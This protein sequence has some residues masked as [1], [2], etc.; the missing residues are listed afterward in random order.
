M[1]ASK[2][3]HGS[4]ELWRETTKAQLHDRCPKNRAHFL[5]NGPLGGQLPI[6]SDAT[7]RTLAVRLRSPYPRVR[8]WLT[9]S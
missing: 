9:G 2:T 5:R 7:T 4:V 3:A 8:S 6:G 1:V